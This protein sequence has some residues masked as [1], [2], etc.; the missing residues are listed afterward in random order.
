MTWR[1]INCEERHTDYRPRMGDD[2]I[3]GSSRSNFM[4]DGVFETE[5][6]D[7]ETHEP[8]LF[9]RK[10]HDAPFGRGPEIECR[11]WEWVP[12]AGASA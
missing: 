3:V 7:R 8:V 9:E 11:H 4:G 12:D 10:R 5:W 2:L 6:V 1:E